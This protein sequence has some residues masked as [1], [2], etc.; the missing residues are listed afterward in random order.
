MIDEIQGDSAP[1]DVSQIPRFISS[2]IA[3]SF[4][5]EARTDRAK[6]EGYWSR[7][8]GACGKPDTYQSGNGILC[9]DDLTTLSLCLSPYVSVPFSSRVSTMIRHRAHTVFEY[10]LSSAWNFNANQL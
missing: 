9:A 7:G 5:L 6:A 8:N 3:T 2:L 10:R 1:L 4:V